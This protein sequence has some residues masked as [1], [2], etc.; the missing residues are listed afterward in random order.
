MRDQRD[1]DGQVKPWALLFQIRWRK[2]YC[3]RALIQGKPA[4]GNRCRHPLPTL[5]H[6]GIR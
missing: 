4:G 3:G 6:R 2:V 5:F 1:G